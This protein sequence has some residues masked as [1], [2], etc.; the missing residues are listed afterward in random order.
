MTTPTIINLPPSPSDPPTPS[1]MGPGNPNSGTASLSALSTTA[2]KDGH[3]GQ[4][5]PHAR[6]SQCSFTTST[7]T[8]EPERTDRISRLAGLGCITTTS[9]G[10]QA[11]SS[12]ILPPYAPAYFETHAAL[13]KC[14][15][16]GSGSATGSIAGCM[17]WASDSDAYDAG[18]ISEDYDQG[19][20]T[21]SVGSD[22]GNENQVRFGEC[23][24]STS[25][26]PI[27]RP[28]GLKRVS[29]RR[30][31]AGPNSKGGSNVNRSTALASYLQEQQYHAGESSMTSL[32]PTPGSR[33]PEPLNQNT[34]TPDG[35]TFDSDLL[36]ITAKSTPLDTSSGR[37]SNGFGS[38]QS[39]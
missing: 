14:S 6:H 26:G 9:A 5:F 4:P 38:Q 21:S 11:S 3:Q 36:D 24:N 23:A 31:G 34:H 13:N 27:P 8:P 33:A 17:T 22:E 15:T 39:G 1:D 2:I 35:M 7:T 20:G 16:V 10:Q 30:L 12:H 25:S 37:S 32:S 28:P 29:S 19:N 18:E